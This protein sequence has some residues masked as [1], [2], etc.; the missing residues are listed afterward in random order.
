[1]LDEGLGIMDGFG[2]EVGIGGRVNRV[3]STESFRLED[4]ELGF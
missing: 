2:I 3:S 1:M 4:L